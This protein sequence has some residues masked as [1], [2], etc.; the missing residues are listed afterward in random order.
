[1]RIGMVTACYKPVIN[2]VTRM[3]SLY[4]QHLEALG[5]EVTVFTL[6]EPDPNGDEPGVIR[7]PAIPLGSTG[8]Y[9]SLGYSH[10]AQMLLQQ[11]DIV[12]C[13][14]LLMSV[15][16]AHRYARCPIVYTNHTRYDLYTGSVT[17]LP[18]PAADALMRQLWPELAGLADA[19]IAPSESVRQVL[20]EFGVSQ[21]IYVIENGIDLRPFR[22]PLAPCTKEDLGIPS[23]AI[24]LLYVGR[25]SPEKS[26][27]LLLEQFVIARD[28]VPN[29]HLAL[30]GKGPSERGIHELARSLQIEDCVHFW[31]TVNFDEVGN[32]MAAADIFVTASRSE[33]HPLTIIEALAAGLPVVASA[34]P[35]IVDTVETGKTGILTSWVEG[36]L[37]AGMVSLAM[38]ESLRREMSQAARQA[39]ERFDIQHTIAKTLALYE[40]LR[41]DRPDLARGRWVRQQNRL[42]PLVEQLTRLLRPEKP[43]TGPLRWLPWQQNEASEQTPE[44]VE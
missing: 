3:V 30:L 28:I 42:Q 16:L 25:F 21:P 11:M 32:Y 10:E 36:G 26:L 18:Q 13:H 14:H 9:F 39:A 35:G 41:E 38:N 33:V 4:K 34:S 6:G 31:G 12:H 1:M 17:P 15:E 27:D 24:L 29:L 8:Y 43:A 19:V 44:K 40:K 5:H 23:D 20:L 7:T 37:T 2:G 22:Q